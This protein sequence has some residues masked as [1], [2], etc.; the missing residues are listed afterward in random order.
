MESE[1]ELRSTNAAFLRGLTH[2]LRTPVGSLLILADLVTE[3]A[4]ERLS[5]GELDKLGKIRRA[6]EDLR[7]LI[8]DV[9][10]LAKAADGTLRSVEGEVDLAELVAE[11]TAELG[12]EA[13]KLSVR[14]EP[15]L[16]AVRADRL[17]LRRILDALLRYAVAAAKAQVILEAKPADDATLVLEIRGLPNLPEEERER[18]FEPFAAASL[19]VQGTSVLKVPVA[20]ALAKLIGVRLELDGDAFSVILEGLFHRGSAR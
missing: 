6:G 12:E 15:N 11:L 4:A 18:I 1:D 14:L 9:S 13:H 20:A 19:R 17:I 7:E 3:S 5:P 2:E 10:I 16:P 8:G